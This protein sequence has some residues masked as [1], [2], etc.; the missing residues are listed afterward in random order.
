NAGPMAPGMLPLVTSPRSSLALRSRSPR[1]AR[2][3]F[4]RGAR[5]STS[6]RPCSDNDS[7]SPAGADGR[8]LP[9]PVPLLHGR[10]LSGDR[11]RSVDERR[12]SDLVRPQRRPQPRGSRPFGTGGAGAL[13]PGL[14]GPALRPLLGPGAGRRP[15][16]SLLL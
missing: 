1:T 10:P 4:F 11:G 14:R 15:P 16:P 13:E 3:A 9:P 12:V 8:R 6:W 7:H 2:S 5:K